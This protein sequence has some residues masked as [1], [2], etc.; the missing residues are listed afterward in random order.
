MQIF[1]WQHK[2][3]ISMKLSVDC[4]LQN[5]SIVKISLFFSVHLCIVCLH[6]LDYLML[7]DLFFSIFVSKV[8]RCLLTYRNAFLLEY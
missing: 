7:Y 8:V 1:P 2:L 3:Y 5:E 4:K 6:F